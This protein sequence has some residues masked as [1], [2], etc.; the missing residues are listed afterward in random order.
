MSSVSPFSHTDKHTLKK[1]RHNSSQTS[2]SLLKHPNTVKCYS[3]KPLYS[4]F[5]EQTTKHFSFNSTARR[6]RRTKTQSS[7]FNDSPGFI[8]SFLFLHF[9]I[10]AKTCHNALACSPVF[11]GFNVALLVKV[12]TFCS[13][14]PHIKFNKKI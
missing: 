13:I 3:K 2:P 4:Y 9:N 14:T 6:A 8:S 11:R 7:V 10:F 5:P 12:L 1:F